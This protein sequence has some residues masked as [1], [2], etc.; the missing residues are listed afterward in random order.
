MNFDRELVRVSV[1][2]GDAV[3]PVPRTYKIAGLRD[4]RVRDLLD[5]LHDDPDFPL[6]VWKR[7]P[8]VLVPGLGGRPFAPDVRLVDL[9]PAVVGQQLLVTLGD[10]MPEG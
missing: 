4:L 10:Y 6:Y 2:P 3:G 9:P 7:P 8:L 5:A 1:F